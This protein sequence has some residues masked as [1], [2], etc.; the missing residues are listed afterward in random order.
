MYTDMS[1]GYL[2]L[3]IY[4]LG[5]FCLATTSCAVSIIRNSIRLTG[6]FVTL[7]FVTVRFYIKW[8]VL[9]CHTISCQTMAY[10][11]SLVHCGLSSLVE[12]FFQDIKYPTL[13][14]VQYA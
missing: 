9:C 8:F 6:Q 3:Q 4:P 14:P 10:N 1:F 5:R 7:G 11:A 13:A 2:H 12:V